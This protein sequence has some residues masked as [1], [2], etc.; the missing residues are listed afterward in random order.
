M[1]I[2]DS[3]E[4]CVISEINYDH[5]DEPCTLSKIGEEVPLYCEKCSNLLKYTLN[6]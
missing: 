3:E 1:F 5:F 2:G 4:E 6:E